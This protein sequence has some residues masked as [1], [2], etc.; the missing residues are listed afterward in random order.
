MCRA[1]ST[2][3]PTVVATPT[4]APTATPPPAAADDDTPRYVPRR[5]C[6]Y[7]PGDDEVKLRKIPNFGVD[8][9]IMDCEDGVATNKKVCKYYYFSI[10]HV[11]IYIF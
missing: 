10:L 3:A 4:A 2:A 9:V 8:C 5:A 7:I 1:A 11:T 6:L